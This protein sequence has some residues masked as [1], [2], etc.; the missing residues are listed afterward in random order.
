MIKGRRVRITN[1]TPPKDNQ[2]GEVIYAF[3]DH[4]GIWLSI[5][6]YPDGKRFIAIEGVDNLIYVRSKNYLKK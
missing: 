4:N 3:K 6:E 5:V 2:I 1:R